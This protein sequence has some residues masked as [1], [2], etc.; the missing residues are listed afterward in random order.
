MLG[1]VCWESARA[2]GQ[3][4]T[5][6]NDAPVELHT[7]CLSTPPLHH[8]HTHLPNP[9]PPPQQTRRTVEQPRLPAF[10][11][12]LFCLRACTRRELH[13]YVK[14]RKTLLIQNEQRRKLQRLWLI[15]RLKRV[16][17]QRKKN[18]TKIRTTL[19]RRQ[20]NQD[21]A[22]EPLLDSRRR[23]RA[24]ARIGGKERNAV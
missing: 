12:P 24:R 5:I 7:G 2:E 14:R 3:T 16:K 1:R 11:P 13:G 15:Q 4:L 23:N 21:T 22:K 6:I 17:T 20:S 18:P 9:P 19:G 10:I 8:P